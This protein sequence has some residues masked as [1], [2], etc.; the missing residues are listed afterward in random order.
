MHS[1][2]TRHTLRLSQIVTK[3]ARDHKRLKKTAQNFGCKA[4]PTGIVQDSDSL[5][6]ESSGF[7]IPNCPSPMATQSGIMLATTSLAY[8]QN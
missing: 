3:R 4:N 7:A 5:G 6:S 1:S 8:D 2:D